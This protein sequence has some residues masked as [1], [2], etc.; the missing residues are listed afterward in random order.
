MPRV[1]RYGPARGV[2]HRYGIPTVVA[3]QRQHDHPDAALVDVAPDARQP[4][5]AAPD[6]PNPAGEEEI[7]LH[8]GRLALDIDAGDDTVV[9][10][11]V[12][13]KTDRGLGLRAVEVPG[14]PPAVGPQDVAARGPHPRLPEVEVAAHQGP[15]ALVAAV[16]VGVPGQPN[17]DALE[18]LPRPAG[19]RE[20]HAGPLE[21]VD[22]EIDDDRVEVFWKGV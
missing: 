8:P 2:D 5:V 6:H 19:I 14:G 18:V 3:G 9:G 16:A 15:P 22:V 11:Q 1:V 4:P 20:R 10:H 12:G 13:Q 7:A 21:Q 17:G